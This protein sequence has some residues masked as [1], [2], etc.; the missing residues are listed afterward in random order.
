MVVRAGG[1][2]YTGAVRVLTS[3]LS[4]SAGETFIEA[5]MGRKSPPTRFG[6]TTQGVFA[7]DMRRKLPD[8]WDFTVGN[9]DYI[10]SDGRNYENTG[11]PPTTQIRTFTPAQQ[12]NT[13][14]PHWTRRYA[15]PGP[16]RDDAAGVWKEA[17]CARGRAGSSKCDQRPASASARPRSPGP[18]Y[19]GTATARCARC[20]SPRR[21]VRCRRSRSQP[22]PRPRRRPGCA[23]EL[24]HDRP[25]F[26]GLRILV[27]R[28]VGGAHT[29]EVRTVVLP[30]LVPWR[31]FRRQFQHRHRKIAAD[32]IGTRPPIGRQHSHP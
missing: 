15:P 11:I 8:G 2:R 7:D 4:I 14:T 26:L 17:G 10:A 20:R 23:H 3:D 9:G 16:T 13:T 22:A 32:Y 5:L 1:P 28:L 6:T 24:A 21:P 19:R 12:P 31:R 25:Y 27:P 29:R 30:S 18:S